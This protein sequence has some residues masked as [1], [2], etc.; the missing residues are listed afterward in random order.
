MHLL[1]ATLL[2]FVACSHD[3]GGSTETSGISADGVVPQ[4]IADRYLARRVP[5]A[6]E[7]V[8][9]DVTGESRDRQLL[10]T[11][12][13]GLL[14]R[15]EARVYLIGSGFS[16]PEIDRAWIDRYQAD[17]LV[18]V[19]LTLSLDRALEA[20]A[21]EIPGYVLADPAEPW[22]I[23]AASTVVAATA[24]VVA[25]PE[26]E[27]ALEAL[28]VPM[29]DDLRGRWPDAATCFTDL[30]D[31]W[32][33]RMPF[34]GLAMASTDKHQIRDWC[35]QQ[36]ILQLDARPG[37]PEYP[38]VY[39]LLD[40]Y[41]AGTT[42]YGYIADNGLQEATA[43]VALSGKSIVLVPSDTTNNLS[44]HSAIGAD[45]PRVVPK[46]VDTAGFT[47]SADDVN[48]VLA[49]SDGDNLRLP[50]GVYEDE[51]WWAHPRRG[52]LPL[53][54]SMGAQVAVL[55]PA[56]WDHYARGAD[57]GSQLVSMM[58]L[59]YTFP[60]QWSDA[61]A[62]YV[63]AFRLDA[64]LGLR[65]Q[66]SLDLYLELAEAA[67]WAPITASG[68][69]AGSAPDGFLLN[70]ATKLGGAPILPVPGDLVV[71]NSQQAVYE[72]DAAALRTQLEALADAPSRAPVTFF[73]VTVWS[74]SYEALLTEV[75]P[76]RER[77]VRFLTPSEG[78]ACARAL[79]GR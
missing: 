32:Q 5:V 57:G 58:G 44:F 72:D 30:V 25:T 19:S 45:T 75:L 37:E 36:G 78:V 42:M 39:A 46:P 77:G 54:W 48:V 65:V 28:G 55:M 79:E 33:D 23:D 1:R 20:H 56:I 41:P 11:T 31:T 52:E 29:L 64:A 15:E 71:L 10:A 49:V 7:V 12:L 68:E 76:L 26:T 73:S 66:W 69:V 40:R 59:G 9:V 43:M 6:D 74:T 70:Y 62:F 2:V 53:G 67:T 22:T 3:P 4:D 8:V 47:C 13:Q 17:G 34:A 35:V 38:T 50:L 60:S 24:G 51:A 27:A 18:N 14:N 21:S 16:E 61:S 63:D